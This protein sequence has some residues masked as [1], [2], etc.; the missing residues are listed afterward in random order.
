MQVGDKF[1]SFD[2]N[3]RRYDENRKIIF[4]GHYYR[5]E[6][7]DETSRSWIIGRE[8]LSHEIFKVPK[9][10]PFRKK[11]GE[12]GVRPIIL[13]DEMVDDECFTQKHARHI[14]EKV[15]GLK[16]EELRKVAS[17]IGYVETEE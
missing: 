15:R 11:Y 2:R 16:A 8:G 13:T 10:D 6:I 1:W 17:L 3:I 14:A 7:I 5:V 12:F 9:S 4:R